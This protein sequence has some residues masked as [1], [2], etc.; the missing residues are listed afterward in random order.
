VWGGGGLLCFEICLWAPA[1]LLCFNSSFHLHVYLYCFCLCLSCM[2]SQ[3]AMTLEARWFSWLWPWDLGTC[4]LSSRSSSLFYSRDTRW[5]Q[6]T[7]NHCVWAVLALVFLSSAL[8]LVPT[9]FGMA[10]AAHLALRPC[11]LSTDPC[12]GTHHPFHPAGAGPSISPPTSSCA[13]CTPRGG[14]GFHCRQWS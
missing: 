9:A 8:C 6:C 11:T 2:Y 5:L 4:P 10:A 13:R 3:H 14:H 12:A 1:G 7:V